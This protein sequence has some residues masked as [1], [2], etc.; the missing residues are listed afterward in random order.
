VAFATTLFLT[1][2]QVTIV[3]TPKT[4]SS[5]GAPQISFDD[6]DDSDDSPQDID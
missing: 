1:P 2:K 4:I 5:P 3:W 6:S